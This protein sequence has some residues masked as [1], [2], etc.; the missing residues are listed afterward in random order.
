ML[1][2]CRFVRAFS[3]RQRMLNVVQ[4]FQYYMMF[5]VCAPRGVC[6]HYDDVQVIEPHWHTLEQQLKGVCGTW[7]DPPRHGSQVATLDD[8]LT[9]HNDFLDTCLKECLLNNPLLLKAR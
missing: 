2:N 5:E 4:N 1:S 6:G 7:S 9:Y 8:V 3:L